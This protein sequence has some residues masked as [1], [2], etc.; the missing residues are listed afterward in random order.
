M[1]YKETKPFYKQEKGYTE[2]PSVFSSTASTDPKYNEPKGVLM[3]FGYT[4]AKHFQAAKRLE[5]D[6]LENIFYVI[7]TKTGKFYEITQDM[8]Y[9][10]PWR[11]LDPVDPEISLEGEICYR[12][13]LTGKIYKFIGLDEYRS[14][15]VVRVDFDAG[16]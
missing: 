5:S 1:T 13:M 8:F 6:T 2:K 11:I 15:S 9:R 4:G 7:S 3:G 14:P 16:S 12:S 10:S